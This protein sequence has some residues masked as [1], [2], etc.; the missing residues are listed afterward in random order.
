MTRGLQTSRGGRAGGSDALAH[1]KSGRSRQNAGGSRTT[2]S[3]RERGFGAPVR[4]PSIGG[5]AIHTLFGRGQ[6][7]VHLTKNTRGPAAP[8]KGRGDGGPVPGGD[9]RGPSFSTMRR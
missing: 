3:A 8:G 9:Q 1:D 6:S 7:L 5:D 2:K 4:I